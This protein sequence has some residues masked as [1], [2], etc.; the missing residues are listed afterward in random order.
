M[1]SPERRPLD[2]QKAN[3]ESMRAIALIVLLATSSTACILGTGSNCSDIAVPGIAVI[4]KDAATGVRI[5]DATVQMTDA[6]GHKQLLPATGS[7]AS[8]EFDGAFDMPGTYSLFI[9]ATGYAA[10]LQNNIVVTN[11]TCHVRTTIVN[12][13]LHP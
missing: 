11:D 13:N 3:G 8:C 12:S 10:D 7:A 9:G 5:C 2:G 4:V 6:A 1:Q